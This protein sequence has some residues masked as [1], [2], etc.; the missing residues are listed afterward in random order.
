MYKDD[1]KIQHFVDSDKKTTVDTRCVKHEEMQFSNKTI[2]MDFGLN[3]LN[4][5]GIII[6]VPISRNADFFYI[7]NEKPVRS[8]FGI[9]SFIE[10]AGS[11]QGL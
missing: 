11:S 7:R 5:A 8:Q 10:I 6:S 9:N 2:W 3:L 1:D 4:E